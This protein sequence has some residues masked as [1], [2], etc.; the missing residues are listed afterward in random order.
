MAQ[1]TAH[2]NVYPGAQRP[3]ERGSDSEGAGGRA[4]SSPYNNTTKSKRLL[5]SAATGAQRL[6]G[7]TGK[8]DGAGRPTGD[9]GPE[10]LHREW[11]RQTLKAC[12]AEPGA[13][14]ASVHNPAVCDLQ[15]GCPPKACTHWWRAERCEPIRLLSPACSPP[16]H[17]HGSFQI[18]RLLSVACVV[19]PL[20]GNSFTPQSLSAASPWLRGGCGGQ[21][22]GRCAMQAPPLENLPHKPSQQTILLAV[23]AA[24]PWPLRR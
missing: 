22:C 21:R 14:F 19:E 18:V 10:S 9:R 8:S 20:R 24:S 23:F 17:V 12:I 1:L 4:L 6:A 2:L 11:V 5:S 15:R 13:Q 7:G 3:A 16:Y